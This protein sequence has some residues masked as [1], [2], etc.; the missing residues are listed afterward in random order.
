[1]QRQL[2]IPTVCVE[3]FESQRDLTRVDSG[4]GLPE[5]RSRRGAVFPVHPSLEI[6][7]EVPTFTEN[8]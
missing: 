7:E 8:S 2:I 1:M 5:R 4:S 3:V 6:A